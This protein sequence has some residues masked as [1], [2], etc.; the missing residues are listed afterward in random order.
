MATNAPSLSETPTGPAAKVPNAYAVTGRFS[1]H[2]GCASS[3]GTALRDLDVSDAARL[4][5]EGSGMGGRQVYYSGFGPQVIKRR[6]V[7]ML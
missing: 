6:G 4:P 7:E 1:Y 5:V 3:L 2:Q